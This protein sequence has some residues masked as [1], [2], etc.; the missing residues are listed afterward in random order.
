MKV[1]LFNSDG[2][3]L[4]EFKP[5]EDGKA[6]LYCCGPTVYNYAHIG[7]MRPYTFEDVLRRTLEYA[8]YDVT[9]VMNVTDVGHLTDDG[10]EGEDKMIKSAREQGMTV[11]E[12]A[13]FFTKAFFR[14]TE[15]LNI[16][17]PHQVCMATKHIQD[18]I[19]MV[20]KLEE[21]GY[22]YTSGEMS[23]SIPQNSLNME[24]WPDWISKTF[25]TAPEPP[26]MK[27]KKMPRT[28]S[29]GSQTANLKIRL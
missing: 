22:T 25:S 29:Y 26:W 13:E 4:Q 18:M 28:L 24:R 19:D 20:K 8:G 1:K 21:K 14:D 12:I 27:I 6:G 23:I 3:E 7:N 17:V 10:D 15:R 11:W 16:N 2:R 5:I 9:H